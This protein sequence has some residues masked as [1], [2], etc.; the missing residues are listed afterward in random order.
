MSSGKLIDQ[1]GQAAPVESLGYLH[2]RIREEAEAAVR[3]ASLEAT[4]AHVHL[5]TAYA[6]RVRQ[7]SGRG[8]AGVDDSWAD[9]HRVW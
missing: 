5:A 3:A 8:A 2:C 7:H 4:L 1:T 9:Q 6:H